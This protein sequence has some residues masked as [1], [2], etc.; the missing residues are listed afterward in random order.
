MDEDSGNGS[1][2]LVLVVDDEEGIRNVLRRHLAQLGYRVA[3]AA[4][5]E[6]ALALAERLEPA[7][8]VTDVHM[9]G[10]DGHALLRRLGPLGLRSSVILMSGRGE[11]DDAI[12]AL[13]QGAVDY[14]KKPWTVEELTAA[15]GRATELFEAL[16]DLSPPAVSP[17]ERG[18]RPPHERRVDA[19]KLVKALAERGDDIELPLPPNKLVRMR[20]LVER[21]GA[22]IDASV[23][24]LLERDPAIVA[25]VFEA[26]AEISDAPSHDATNLRGAAVSIGLQAVRSE[27]EACA[28]HDAFPIA[29]PALRTLA[30]RLRGFARARALAMRGIAEIAESEVQLDPDACYRAGLWLDV[31]AMY[32]LSVIS[33]TLQH[34]GVKIANLPAMN[35]AIANHH[36]SV[37]ASILRRWGMGDELV[38]LTLD[39][40]KDALVRNASPLWCAAALGGAIALRVTGYGDPTESRDLQPDLL[41]RCAYTLGVGDSSLRRVTRLLSDRP[42]HVAGAAPPAIGSVP[43]SSP[44]PHQR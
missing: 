13:R 14:L 44:S 40:H 25:A 5:G 41:A 11:L 22:E 42:A 20:E 31:G 18:G 29:V 36:G 28:I 39:H 23:L 1:Q 33:E 26:A 19:A 34:R 37:G 43:R 2:R 12:S 35:Q 15:I 6:E 16:R 8:I 7:V 17:T 38:E 24:G 10:M 27:V 4:S 30:E 32:F 9:P 3:T 21:P